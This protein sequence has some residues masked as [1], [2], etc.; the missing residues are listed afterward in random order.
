MA[1]LLA[2]A[3]SF[4]AGAYAG[5]HIEEWLYPCEVACDFS[6]LAGLLVGSFVGPAIA[7]PLVTH[8]ANGR[9][10]R[11]GIAYGAAAAVAGAGFV[12]LVTGLDSSIGTLFLF[13]TPLAQSVAALL[14]ERVGAR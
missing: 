8:L 7:T 4:V 1:S 14:I 12:G 3:G 10:G 2:S 6:G 11:L 5:Y 9:R 13:G